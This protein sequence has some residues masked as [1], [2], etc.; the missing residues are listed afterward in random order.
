M[1]LLK[2]LNPKPTISERD[3]SSGLRWLALEG[4]FSIGFFSIT[5]SGFLAAFALALGANNLQ[6]GILAA[7]PFAMQ[8]VQIPSIWLV[9]RVRRRKIIGVTSWFLAQT[10]WIPMALIPIFMNVPGQGAITFLLVMM[11][12]RGVLSA[13]CNTAWNGWIRDLVPQT[14]LGR[15]FSRRLSIATVIGMAFSL[16]AAFFVDFWKGQ[17]ADDQLIMGYVY[18]LLF[19]SIFL[20]LASPV[21]MSLIPEPLMQPSPV[22]HIPL[23]QRLLAPIRDRNFRRLLMFLSLW[24]F[25]S[26]LAIPFF[27][28][29]ML[30]RLGFPLS[31]VIAFSILSQA[32]NILFLRVWGRYVDR[33]GTKAVLSLC[34]SLYLLVIAGWIFTTMPERYFLTIPLLFLLHIFAGIATAGVNIT[35]GT[36]GLKLAPKGE[37]TSYLANASLAV[38]IGAGLGP[39]LG[40]FL[41]DFFMTRQINLTLSWISPG[42]AVELPALSILGYD[43]LFAI[44]F[45]LG[46]IT[47][48]LLA[49]VREEGEVTRETILESL[50][51]PARDTSRPASM[52]PQYNLVSASTLGYIKRIPIPGL[53]ALLGVTAY[54]IAETARAATSA[55]VR[56]RRLTKRLAKAL[57]RRLSKV[58][59]TKEGMFGV[60]WKVT[61]L[62]VSHQRVKHC[63][64]WQLW[65][66]SLAH[67]LSC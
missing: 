22:P 19:G 53:D 17:V 43:F 55:A 59:K 67:L 40:G 36:I 32:F 48:S 35:V 23:R 63:H 57:E 45:I 10:L 11:T 44:A 21:M 15:F 28:V 42:T 61:S 51:Y 18:V 2:F 26:N 9:E 27:A 34:V 60:S 38:N 39:M 66:L 54:Q 20:G 65:L 41:A 62:L 25:A 52:V 14:I 7:I 24:G 47:L 3:L 30:V 16:G 13:I 1:Q 56:G 31:W 37:S 4:G 5:T 50:V 49:A 12:F 29:Y 33:F 46:L 58:W 6:I 8:I 64:T